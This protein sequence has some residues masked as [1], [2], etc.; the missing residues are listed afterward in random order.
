L[1]SKKKKI[2]DKMFVFIYGPRLRE[3][4]F[5]LKNWEWLLKPWLNFFFFSGHVF[6]KK[7]RKK[8]WRKF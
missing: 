7:E 5:S 1:D 8:T 4:T 6:G 3:K 2:N